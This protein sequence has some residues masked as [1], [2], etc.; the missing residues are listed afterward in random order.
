MKEEEVTAHILHSPSSSK[1][2]AGQQA[3]AYLNVRNT[4]YHQWMHPPVTTE[5]R[6]EVE[7]E[8]IKFMNYVPDKNDSVSLYPGQD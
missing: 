3:H 1:E 8:H 6:V 5:F 4:E 2:G 7:W